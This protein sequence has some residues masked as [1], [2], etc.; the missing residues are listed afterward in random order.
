MVALDLIFDQA[1]DTSAPSSTK[2]TNVVVNIRIIIS[3]FKHTESVTEQV[4]SQ[5]SKGKRKKKKMVVMHLN[6]FMEIIFLIFTFYFL[7]IEITALSRNF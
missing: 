6:L 1:S 5:K 7:K 4:K 3:G 2:V